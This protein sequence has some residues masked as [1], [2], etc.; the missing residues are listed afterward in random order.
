MFLMLKEQGTRSPFLILPFT[1]F[2]CS[3]G[4]RTLNLCPQQPLF[5]LDPRLLEIIL[6]LFPTAGLF[7]DE[8]T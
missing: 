5:L 1:G 6:Q 8:D 2:I 7:K 3:N 4:R